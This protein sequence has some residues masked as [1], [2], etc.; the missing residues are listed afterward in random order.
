MPIIQQTTQY[1]PYHQFSFYIT[2]W[3]RT[4]CEGVSLWSGIVFLAVPET[5][6]QESWE[7]P[8]RPQEELDQHLRSAHRPPCRPASLRLSP[9]RW[10]RRPRQTRASAVAGNLLKA[11][12]DIYR[13]QM[14]VSMIWSGPLPLPLGLLSKGA[15]SYGIHPEHTPVATLLREPRRAR[16]LRA[17]V[18][19]E[20]SPRREHCP[21]REQG[22]SETVGVPFTS[23]PLPDSSRPRRNLRAPMLMD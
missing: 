10:P 12:A 20:H 15:P 4:V 14:Q 1:H 8:N 23:S 11:K 22:H 13:P 19:P 18:R 3:R 7:I 2:P 21:G 9:R 16:P 6:G 17:A 5:G